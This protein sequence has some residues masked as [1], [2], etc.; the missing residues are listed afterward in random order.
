MKD[1]AVGF[2]NR[3]VLLFFLRNQKNAVFLVT[4]AFVHN[5]IST[6]L[7]L[8]FP[9]ILSHQERDIH[10]LVRVKTQIHFFSCRID[11]SRNPIQLA[12]CERGNLMK[13]YFEPNEEEAQSHLKEPT[14]ARRAIAQVICHE[15][16]IEG[17]CLWNIVH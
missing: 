12:H 3:E 17:T 13:P 6:S 11:L 7:I 1:F 4:A 10:P 15:D 2:I 8:T 16:D 14:K 5:V 9:V